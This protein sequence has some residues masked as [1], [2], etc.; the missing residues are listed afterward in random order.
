MQAEGLSDSSR[1]EICADAVVWAS[2]HGLVSTPG[3]WLTDSYR[4]EDPD[5]SSSPTSVQVYG[6]GRADLPA[7]LVHAPLAVFPVTYPKASYEKAQAAMPV[8]NLL[9]D[10]ISR[11]SSYLQRTLAP[12]AEF[13]DFTVSIWALN[14]VLQHVVSA[15][16]GHMTYQCIGKALSD[17]TQDRMLA[18]HLCII[19]LQL[20]L[21]AIS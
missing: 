6:A 16:L 12:A 8:F 3:P 18:R 2:Q 14:V 1:D 9:I 21:P 20:L 11:D 10:R 17:R 7:A 4:A 15:A 5:H 19:C 13:D